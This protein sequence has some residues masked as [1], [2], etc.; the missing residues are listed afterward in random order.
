MLFFPR[1]EPTASTLTHRQLLPQRL[2]SQKMP[3]QSSS[4]LSCA[5]CFHCFWC[6]FVP[7]ST[8]RNLPRRFWREY[9][10]AW[11]CWGSASNFFS[12]P[13]L[14]MPGIAP[15][16]LDQRRRCCRQAKQHRF[17]LEMSNASACDS[18]TSVMNAQ[19]HHLF[20]VCC[21]AVCVGIPRVETSTCKPLLRL[22]IC[23]E[24]NIHEHG[25]SFVTTSLDSLVASAQAARMSARRGFDSRQNLPVT[26][27]PQKWREKEG[28]NT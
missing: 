5:S 25:V 9:G 24:N 21:V 2:H 1:R 16:S 8:L 28:I 15:H 4:R 20:K 18:N 12:V 17:I 27:E 10:P 23:F 14:E 7:C 13:V 22:A 11:F 3:W 19:E 26:Y 6:C